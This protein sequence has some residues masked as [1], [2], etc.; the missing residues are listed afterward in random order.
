MSLSKK[1]SA[2]IILLMENLTDS[3]KEETIKSIKF[4]VLEDSPM[5]RTQSARFSRIKTLFKTISEDEVFLKKIRPDPKI[6]EDIIKDNV[7]TRD[8]RRLI[9]ITE[10]MINKILKIKDSNDPHELAIFL[11]FVS[12]RR[13]AELLEAEFINKKKIKKVIIFGVKKRTDNT[14][15][16]FIPLINKTRFFKQLRRFDMFKKFINMDTFHRTLNRKIKVILGESFKPHTLRGMFVT[17][18][19]KFR[20]KDNLKINTF[21]MRALCHQSIN[22]S[23]NYTQYRITFDKDIL[24]NQ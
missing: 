17:Y 15:C 9:N 1:I 16:Q 23:L 14:E 2:Q 6:T 18:S 3:N 5:P 21:I 10:E 24:I 13:V 7:E 12:G 11:L 4:I 19:F 8:E 20:N 22:S